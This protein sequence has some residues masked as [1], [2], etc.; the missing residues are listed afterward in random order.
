MPRIQVYRAMNLNSKGGR[1]AEENK[2]TQQPLRSSDQITEMRCGEQ[3]HQLGAQGKCSW[4]EGQGSC[5]EENMGDRDVPA[6]GL[7]FS[8]MSL[9]Q[10]PSA[11]GEGSEKA[12]R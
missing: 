7:P 10:K 12:L 3:R 6:P 4:K 9:R 2:H 1:Q 8:Q 11:E 5:R